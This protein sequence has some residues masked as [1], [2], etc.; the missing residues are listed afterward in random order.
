MS[1]PEDRGRHTPAAIEDGRRVADEIRPGGTV[2]PQVVLEQVAAA[3]SNGV[4]F[5]EEGS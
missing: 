1:D 2:L 3:G 5:G 4:R